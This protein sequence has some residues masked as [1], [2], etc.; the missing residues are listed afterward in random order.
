MGLYYNQDEEDWLRVLPTHGG[1]CKVYGTLGAKQTAKQLGL[2]WIGKIAF[3]TYTFSGCRSAH[4]P[5]NA[6]VAYDYTSAT[7]IFSACKVSLVIPILFTKGSN[8]EDI[9]CTA[10]SCTKPDIYFGGL[11][12]CLW[13]QGPAVTENL[14]TGGNI[15]LT[16]MLYCQAFQMRLSLLQHQLLLRLL[17]QVSHRQYL[18][19]WKLLKP[20]KF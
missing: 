18:R 9:S 15:L 20:R 7:D 4:Y 6:S 11:N 10:W 16:R 12:T 14:I 8:G 1:F 17:R 5:P 2:L 3:P 19:Q 13:Q